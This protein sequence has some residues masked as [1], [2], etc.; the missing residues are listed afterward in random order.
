MVKKSLFIWLAII[1][2]AILN[3]ALREG[4]INPLTGVKYGLPLSGVSL[5]CIIFALCWFCIPRIGKGTAKTY[6]IIGLWWMILTVFFETGFGLLMGNTFAEL[7]K[8]YDIT[9]G[10]L[11]LL[12]VL[13][14]GTTPRLI[15]K[16]KRIL[17]IEINE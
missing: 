3:G 17:I 13:F 4:V 10:N 8:A 14:T 9:T 1:P 12:C 15:A 6:W 2:L 5:C 16:I 7:V 11:W